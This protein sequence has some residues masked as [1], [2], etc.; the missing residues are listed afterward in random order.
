[1]TLSNRLSKVWIT[2][3]TSAACTG[4][5]M[6]LLATLPQPAHA[7]PPR[8]T[9]PPTI[10]ENPS[11]IGAQIQLKAQFP[12]DWPWQTT[13][14]QDLWTQVQW[15][16]TNGAWHD[17]VG[18]QGT[19]DKVEI[20]KDETVMGFKTWWLGPENLGDGP[21]RWRRCQPRCTTRFSATRTTALC[22]S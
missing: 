6:A 18:W 4:L 17:V 8:P 19:L 12:E 21:M 2:L 1:M 13:H 5:T 3:I 20:G 7:L 15:Q 14:W 22:W 16:D 11:S 10:E 9:V